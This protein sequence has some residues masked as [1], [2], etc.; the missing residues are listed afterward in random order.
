[1]FFFLKGCQIF[2]HDHTI[3]APAHRGKNI[4]F[5][6]TGLGKD[7][8]QMKPLNMLLKENNHSHT[9]I[10]FLKV[11]NLFIHHPIIFNGG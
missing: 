6:K 10:E 2:A 4:K 11:N 3:D 5:F 1:M 8:A 7:S 9:P